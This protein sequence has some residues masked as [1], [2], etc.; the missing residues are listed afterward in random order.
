MTDLRNDLAASE[1]TKITHSIIMVDATIAKRWLDHNVT[2]RTV[3]Q[4]AVARYCSDMEHGRW[5]MAGDPIRFNIDG[6]LVDGQHRLIALSELEG[7]TLPMLVIRGLPREAQGAMDQGIKR[8]PGDQLGLKGVR[9][10]QS[11]AAAVKQFIAWDDDLLFRDTKVLQAITS[12]QIEEWCDDHPHDV[13]FLQ[14]V[15]SLTRQNDARPAIAAAAAIAFAR[16]DA[17][18]A[19]DFFTLLARGA[20]TQGHP[21]VTLDKRLQRMRRDNVKIP[22]R[23][24]LALFIVAWNAWRAGKTVTKFQRPVGGRYTED[25]FPVPR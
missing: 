21:I 22:D 2:N 13:D 3:R 8:T 25:N 12:T 6:D 23:D 18:A 10:G 20:G 14:Q 7:I 19:V 11:I 24:L 1:S 5:T 9:N 15:L 17:Q 4:A 16:I